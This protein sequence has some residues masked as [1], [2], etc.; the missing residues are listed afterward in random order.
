VLPLPFSTASA[1]AALCGWGVYADLIEVDAG[2]DFH[3]AWADINLAW[4]VLRPGGVMFGH[5]YFTF[6]GGR[7]AVTLFAKVK[8]LTIHPHGQHW[9][10]SPKPRGNGPR[11]RPVSGEYVLVAVAIDRD[12]G[13]ALAIILR[14]V[15]NL[16]CP[17]APAPCLPVYVL[18][19]SAPTLI[20]SRRKRLRRCYYSPKCSFQ[21]PSI[22]FRKSNS[23]S[24]R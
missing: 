24:A 18:A 4:A 11:Q 10:L 8:G 19:G 20:K 6:A 13:N 1:L 23:A 5:D 21:P 22:F 12:P 9:V 17:V 7:R 2:H 14:P 15:R 3:S 16:T